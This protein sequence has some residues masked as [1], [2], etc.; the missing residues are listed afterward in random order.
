MPKIPKEEMPEILPVSRKRNTLLRT[1][2]L[3]LK[4]GEG[5]FLPRSEWKGKSSPAHVIARLKKL[6]I[7]FDY[8]FKT[9]GSGWL[10]RR[11]G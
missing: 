1:E 11:V 6:G 8:G 4:V 9:D 3:Q 2:L 10:F 7:Q 5:Y